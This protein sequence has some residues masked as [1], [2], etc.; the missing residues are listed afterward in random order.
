MIKKQRLTKSNKRNVRNIA[1]V[2]GCN[3]S[4]GEVA[5]SVGSCVA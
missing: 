3:C 1:Y 4:K 5:M 2:C